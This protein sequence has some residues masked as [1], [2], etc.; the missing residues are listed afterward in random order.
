MTRLVKSVPARARLNQT[1]PRLCKTQYSYSSMKQ[2]IANPNYLLAYLL[3]TKQMY[4]TTLDLDVIRQLIPKLSKLYNSN[5]IVRVLYKQ[6][7]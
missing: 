1:C 4:I 2:I 7:N 3:Q 5:F 6:L